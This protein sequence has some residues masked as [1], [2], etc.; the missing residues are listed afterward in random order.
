MSSKR[1]RAQLELIQNLLDRVL[2]INREPMTIKD[3]QARMLGHGVVISPQS[4]SA[5]LTQLKKVKKCLRFKVRVS[6][7]IVGYREFPIYDVFW[8]QPDYTYEERRS[9][10]RRHSTQWKNPKGPRRILS[11]S[12]D[13]MRQM[14][15][16][17]RHG[18]AYR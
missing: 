7:T 5:N 12:T 15:E 2:R 18:Y 13:D 14:V 1:S 6:G 10:Y 3:I 11:P 4:I 8:V 16:D 17:L 9:F